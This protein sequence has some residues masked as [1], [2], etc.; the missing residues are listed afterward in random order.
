MEVDW[1]KVDLDEVLRK[2]KEDEK[3]FREAVDKRDE[4]KIQALKYLVNFNVLTELVLK[5]A[6]NED[7]TLLKALL[8]RDNGLFDND[9]V[10]RHFDE[11]PTKMLEFIFTIGNMTSIF[12]KYIDCNLFMLAIDKN[13]KKVVDIILKR[14]PSPRFL[15]ELSCSTKKT[16]LMF[17]AEQGDVNLVRKMLHLGAD[18]CVQNIYD[19]T[20][21]TYT[22]N[23]DIKRLLEK[24][25]GR[26]IGNPSAELIKLLS[27]RD[28]DEYEIEKLIRRGADINY[29]N[30]EPLVTSIMK[31]RSTAFYSLINR[32]VN[33]NFITENGMTPLSLVVSK[34]M[35]EFI[36]PILDLTNKTFISSED[37]ATG[38]TALHFYLAPKND[39]QYKTV[40][41]F[42]NKGANVNSTDHDGIT[43][44]MLAAKHNN[45]DIVQLFLEHNANRFL[46]DKSQKTA[47]QYTTDKKV[48][49]ILS[50]DER[51][52]PLVSITY[53]APDVLPSQYDAYLKVKPYLKTHKQYIDEKK[54]GQLVKAY[55]K[56]TYG[57]RKGNKQ[58]DDLLKLMEEAPGFGPIMLYSSSTYFPIRSLPKKGDVFCYPRILSTSYD[59]YWSLFSAPAFFASQHITKEGQC[60]VLAFHSNPPYLFIPEKY[61][62]YSEPEVIIPPKSYEVTNLS[63]VKVSD[64]SKVVMIFLEETNKKSTIDYLD[65]LNPS[66]FKIK[67]ELCKKLY[68]SGKSLSDLKKIVINSVDENNIVRVKKIFRYNGTLKNFPHFINTFDKQGL[69]KVLSEY[70]VNF[71]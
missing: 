54:A 71:S 51:S 58:H 6:K 12:S 32:G 44:L 35:Q 31:I 66:K 62:I 45:S 53:E 2:V 69:C 3:L 13:C 23:N 7:K 70:Y 27:N 59:L 36:A 21:S 43:P 8:F 33:V 20:A 55:V 46:K 49:F 18:P 26:I 10:A 4:E 57:F 30:G 39:I 68:I 42:L 29:N 11:I 1:D 37:P 52:R 28:E 25:I 38:K 56:G 15:D 19:E 48:K 64:I 63:I 22:H 34:D 65:L 17:A 50:S 16:A 61:A 60:C 47:L 24:P 67:E 9:I 41:D 40:L 5:A 14:K